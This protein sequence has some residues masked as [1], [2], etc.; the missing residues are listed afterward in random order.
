[1][2]QDFTEK[3]ILIAGAAGFIP[4]HVSTYY[5]ERGARVIGLDNFITGQK[6]NIDRLS[7]YSGFHFYHCN[8]FEELPDL[9]AQKIDYIFSLASPASPID[10]KKI[11]MEIMRVNSEGT[12][13][14]LELAKNKKARFLE[15][16][17]SEVYGDPEIHPQTETYHGNV[18]TVGP[19]SCYDESKRYAEA[20]TMNYHWQ[21]GVDTRIV[22]IFNTYGPGMRADDGRVIPN[23]VNQVLKGENITVNGDGS[24]T[25]SFCYVDDLVKA[26]HAVMMSEEITPVNIGNP[27]EY[28]IKECAELILK[29]LGGNSKITYQPLPQD[30]PKKRRP[31]I[32]K[33]QR[34][35]TYRPTVSF[36]EGLRKTAEYFKS[37]L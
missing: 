19:R 5:L 13:K 18:N 7:K 24:Q 37:K 23:F 36:E 2:E 3:S 1:M 35:S 22:R 4:S 20:L 31:N 8:I 27:D 29:F 25:R 12:R 33:L 10:F 6:E 11:P 26:M 30:D 15:A 14:L 16:S 28:T 17:T 9:S 32:D 34:I 21:Y